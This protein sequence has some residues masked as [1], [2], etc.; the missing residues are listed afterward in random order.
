MDH[1]A[2]PKRDEHKSQA[3]E[4]EWLYDKIF[5][6]YPVEERRGGTFLEIGALDGSKYS[7]TWYYEKKWD[8]RGVLVEGHPQ[9][10]RKLRS[11]CAIFTAAVCDYSEGRRTG[12]LQFTPGGG[13]TGTV[14]ADA[15]P[16][17][18]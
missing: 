11:N 13:E 18:I 4:D 15:S 10:T 2:Q 5:S 3:H 12:N 16:I 8:W 7:N 9:N 14:M 6:K 1:N 17:F